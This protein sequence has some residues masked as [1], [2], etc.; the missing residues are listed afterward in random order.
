MRRAA[1]VLDRC[2]SSNQNDSERTGKGPPR[3]SRISAL[4]PAAGV[5]KPLAVGE[6]SAMMGFLVRRRGLNSRRRA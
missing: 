6:L 4:A 3:C 1:T 5:V 2:R